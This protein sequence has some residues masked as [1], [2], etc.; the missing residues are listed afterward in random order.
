MHGW[1]G[2]PKTLPSE[3][4]CQTLAPALTVILIYHLE[5]RW[6]ATHI[7]LGLSWPL[8]KKPPFGSGNRHLLSPRCKYP[9]SKE[10][11]RGR[12]GG[13]Q[14]MP[15]FRSRRGVG[16]SWAGAGNKGPFKKSG[17]VSFLL[18]NSW[19]FHVMMDEL[20]FKGKLPLKFEPNFYDMFRPNAP[21]V[22]NFD[23]MRSFWP[24]L[25]EGFIRE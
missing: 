21:S 23:L 24:F 19:R 12:G 8:T 20:K 16:W 5:S 13:M 14:M 25:L 3:L 1:L 4:Y 9:A 7:S 22:T 11:E 2:S 15:W 17:W 18:D 6:L 10:R